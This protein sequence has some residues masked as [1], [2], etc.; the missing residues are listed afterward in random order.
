MN[1]IRNVQIVQQIYA[2]FEKRDI[3]NLLTMVSDGVDWQTFGPDKIAHAGPHRGRDQ[4]RRFFATIA[5]S[6]NR[7][8]LLRK[9][10]RWSVSEIMPG[11]SKPPA[12]NMP[13]N[14]RTLLRC[15]TA[16]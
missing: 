5:D 10:T 1:E 9:A 16:K 7:A 3:Q 11:A 8:S 2:A 13:V 4:V 15:A 6:S 12:A 14:G